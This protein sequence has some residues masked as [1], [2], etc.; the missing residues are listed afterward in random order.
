VVISK[1]TDKGLTFSKPQAISPTPANF[2]GTGR[3]QFFPGVAVDKDGHVGVC[4]Y[5]RRAEAAN[6]VID[7]YCSVSIDHGRSWAEQRV[8]ASNWVPAHDADSLINPSYMG[9]YDALTSDTLGTNGGFLGAYEVENQGNPDV[10][11]KRF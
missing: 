2:A 6:T 9:D 3:D 11:A 10:F 5:D 8:S 1:S 4:Y 7:R